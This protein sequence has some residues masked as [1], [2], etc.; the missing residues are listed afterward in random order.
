MKTFRRLHPGVT[1]LLISAAATLLVSV[2]LSGCGH[3]QAPAAPVSLSYMGQGDQFSDE[4][5][6]EAAALQALPPAPGS[7]P[8]DSF[9]SRL[10]L[11]QDGQAQ[12]MVRI[13]QIGDSHTAG[14]FLSGDLRDRFQSSFGNAGIGARVPGYAYPGLR[15][16]DYSVTQ[17]GYWQF[18]NSLTDPGFGDYGISGFTAVSRSAGA[19]MTMTPVNALG[20]DYAFVDFVRQ[21]GGG[22]FEIWLD[23]TLVQR[24][25]TYGLA[26]V[27]GHVAVRAPPGGA[28]QLMIV[29]QTTGVE[30]LDW[31]TERFSRGIVMDSFGVVGSTAGIFNNWNPDT[32]RRQLEILHPALIILAY[33][34]NEGAEPDFDPVAYEA[35]FAGILQDLRSWAPYSSILIEAPTDGAHQPP[36]CGADEQCPWSALPALDQVRAIQ[37]Q[38][39]QRFGAAY[40]DA[41]VPEMVSGGI[42]HWADMYPPLAR[43]D[44]VHFTVAGYRILATSLYVWLMNGYAAYQQTH[45]GLALN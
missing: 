36:G 31:D 24:V 32:V 44:H 17:T 16:K 26:G 28:H 30:I 8:L 1:D 35:I 43:R 29:A 38:E 12:Q 22:S 14:D 39:A 34:T 2:A 6:I 25:S 41:S 23:D 13:L 4:L 5:S 3:T 45:H 27:M 19:S 42:D 33:G 20:F 40:F 21:P 10:D 11:L 37:L 15:E 9:F 7:G 18:H